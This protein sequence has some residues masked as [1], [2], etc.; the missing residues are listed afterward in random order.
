M[1]K[2]HRLLLVSLSWGHQYLNILQNSTI[3]IAVTQVA[4]IS[5]EWT[6]PSNANSSTQVNGMPACVCCGPGRAVTHTHGWEDCPLW[7]VCAVCSFH[8]HLLSTLLLLPHHKPH[9]HTLGPGTALVCSPV[10]SV[11]Q[12]PLIRGSCCYFLQE[13]I[14]KVRQRILPVLFPSVLALIPPVPMLNPTPIQSH[15]S[16]HPQRLFYFR[17]SVSTFEPSLLLS[18]LLYADDINDY[19]YFIINTH[20]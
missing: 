15:P 12:E 4:A 8:K 9:K 19:P 7:L 1:L 6:L 5:R 20:L 13:E 14:T 11:V 3:L 18:F 16:I 2:N 17:F 10:R